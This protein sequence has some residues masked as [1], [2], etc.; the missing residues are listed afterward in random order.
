MD[1][2]FIG[3]ISGIVTGLG[4]GGGSILIIVLVT[5]LGVTQHMAQATNLLFFIPT[6]V[7]SIWVHIQNKNVEKS[8][9][10]KLF[11][12]TILGSAAGAYFTTQVASEHLK[13]YFGFF[14]LAVGVYEFIS[15]IKEHRKKKKEGQQ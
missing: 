15:T 13:Q 1:L 12:T 5:F 14:L 9:A 2:I 7:L 8:I 11:F 6:S 3:M 4:M 10:K